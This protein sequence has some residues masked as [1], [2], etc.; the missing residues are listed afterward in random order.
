MPIQSSFGFRSLPQ[1]E[2]R[3][4]AYIVVW[5]A[6]EVHR[7]LI[8]F[9]KEPSF[10]KAMKICLEDRAR[11]EVPVTVVFENFSKTYYLDL[12][13][14]AGAI[15]ELKKVASINDKHRSQL[16]HYLMLTNTSLGKLINFGKETVDHEFVNS[17]RDLSLRQQFK[18][19]RSRWRS[20]S[21]N[22]EFSD[23]LIGLL[24]DWGTG[25]DTNLYEEAV[26][27]LINNRSETFLQTVPINF[28]NCIIGDFAA[29]TL[30]RN[31]AFSITAMNSNSASHFENQLHTLLAQTDIKMINWAN[32]HGGV[33]N[34]VSIS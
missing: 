23:T 22:D 3:E 27:T 32:I 7:E 4:I 16:L 1:S 29:P 10:T 12:V 5:K 8:R 24:Q 25:L 30:T 28:R 14:D 19:D 18:V 2:F 33:V 15:F 31:R 17:G 11:T 20:D 34:F 9:S 6:I 13:V 21:D 26:G